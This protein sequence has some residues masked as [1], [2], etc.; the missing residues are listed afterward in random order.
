MTEDRRTL[1]ERL[2][3]AQLDSLEQKIRGCNSASELQDLMTASRELRGSYVRRQDGFMDFNPSEA[4]DAPRAAAPQIDP[5]VA[6]VVEGL[7]L[8]REVFRMPKNRSFCEKSARIHIAALTFFTPQSSAT[9]ERKSAATP[10]TKFADAR[11]KGRI[12]NGKSE[13]LSNPIKRG[14]RRQSFDDGYGKLERISQMSGGR[15]E[16][17]SA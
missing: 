12:K 7:H 2:P 11:S 3:G 13:R 16:S 14:T 4:M 15:T 6:K 10:E 5:E 9:A 1:Q 17:S 8:L